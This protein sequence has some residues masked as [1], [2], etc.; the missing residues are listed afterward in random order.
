MKRIRE[1]HEYLSQLVEVLDV[2]KI[3]IDAFKEGKK[4]AWMIIS[5][6]LFQLLLDYSRNNKP[7][8]IRVMPPLDFHFLKSNISDIDDDG[9][10]YWIFN[11]FNLNFLNNGLFDF[12]KKRLPL[13]KWLKQTIY[14]EK[15]QEK[16]FPVNIEKLLYWPRR[17]GGGVHFDKEV[18]KETQIIER[19]LS[20]IQIGQDRLSFRDYLFA[21]GDYVYSEMSSQLMGDLGNGYLSQGNY[22]KAKEFFEAAL[23]IN[24]EVGSIQGQSEQLNRIGWLN[25]KL[26]DYDTAIRFCEEALSLSYKINGNETSIILKNL[27]LFK[28]EKSQ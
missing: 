18:A 4:S 5:A 28:I 6:F 2:L 12:E 20:F 25:F 1:E 14:I 10:P 26:K 11:Y 27:E 19:S 9:K 13:K 8:A 3:G 23:S 17:Q 22:E 15:D 16:G 7:L 21:I 24:R